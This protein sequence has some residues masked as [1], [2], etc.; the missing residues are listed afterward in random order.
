MFKHPKKDTD[1]DR[2]NVLDMDAS[3]QGSL[4]FKDHVDL[5]ISGKFEGSLEVKGS[6]TVGEMAVVNAEIKGEEITISGK[7]MGDISATSRLSL[8]GTARIIGDISTPV[9]EVQEGAVLQG[10]CQMLTQEQK[11]GSIKKQALNCQQL[12]EYLE[13]GLNEVDEWIKN[14]KIPAFKENN[15]WKFDKAKIDAWVATEKIK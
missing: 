11:A 1:E 10:N 2:H 12:A 3:M 4:V 7:V 15:E 14:H 13:V 8:T 5:K 9:L 6:L